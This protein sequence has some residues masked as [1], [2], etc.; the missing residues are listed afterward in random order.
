VAG[1]EEVAF[2]VEVEGFVEGLE[3]GVEELLRVGFCSKSFC[4]WE[5]K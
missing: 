3:G 5:M 1:H 4:A 2:D